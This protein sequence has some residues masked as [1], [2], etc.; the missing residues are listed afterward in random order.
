MAVTMDRDM[1]RAV[2]L[3]G[4]RAK[5]PVDRRND[6]AVVRA[7]ASAATLALLALAAVP[8]LGGAQ[9]P[10]RD[11]SD[12]TRIER[13]L[14]RTGSDTIGQRADDRRGVARDSASVLDAAAI[15]NAVSAM[16]DSVVR[17]TP[18]VPIYRSRSD[19]IASIRTR[20]AAD[21]EKDLRIVISL[22]ERKLWALIGPDTL[23]RA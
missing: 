11:T 19:S 15:A 1:G 12:W 10:R 20:L 6:V 14:A 3:G 16:A 18:L 7:V 22:N 13:L 2:R 4:R 5:R 23:L 8:A 9:S 17:A 21:R